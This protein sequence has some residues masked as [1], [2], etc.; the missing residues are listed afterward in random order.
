VPHGVSGLWLVPRD[1]E[2]LELRTTPADH[3]LLDRR[4]AVELAEALRAWAGV[5]GRVHYTSPADA[6][7]PACGGVR[8]ESG[9][10][11]DGEE[12]TVFTTGVLDLV[13]CGRCRRTIAY[14]LAVTAARL[15]ETGEEVPASPLRSP[16]KPG[17]PP[18]CPRGAPS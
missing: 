8:E 17:G 5:L 15:R 1:E 13:D 9:H 7:Q 4:R 18:P 12:G 3:A 16:S 10:R 2:H 6:E 11:V 14:A